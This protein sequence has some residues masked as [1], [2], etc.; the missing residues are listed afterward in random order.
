MLRKKN[1]QQYEKFA[2]VRDKK[3]KKPKKQQLFFQIVFAV[4]SAYN[5]THIIQIYNTH[6][7][8]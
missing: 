6:S 3:K 4:S 2:V 8:I 1:I 7:S 5:I